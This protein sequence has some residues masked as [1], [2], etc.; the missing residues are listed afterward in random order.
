[1]SSL[2]L[3][4]IGRGLRVPGGEGG[5]GV[6]PKLCL[7]NLEEQLSAGLR[8]SWETWCF[9][10]TKLR[11]NCWPLTQAQ[12]DQCACSDSANLERHGEA[13]ATEDFC[14]PRRSSELLRGVWGVPSCWKSTLRVQ[15]RAA[16][17]RRKNNAWLS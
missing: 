13:M 6:V 8:S 17:G 15:V 12:G 2:E 16:I 4:M 14:R 3:L 5:A 11:Q 9:R 7:E 1:M 10:I